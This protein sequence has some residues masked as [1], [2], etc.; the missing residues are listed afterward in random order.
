MLGPYRRLAIVRAALIE[1]PALLALVGYLAGG[2]GAALGV[3]AVAVALL[4]ASL[5]SRAQLQRFADD[6]LQP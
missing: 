2:S 4:V 3:A 5:P 1:A 6:A